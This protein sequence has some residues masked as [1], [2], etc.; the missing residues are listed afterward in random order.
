MESDPP[1][2]ERVELEPRY[3]GFQL[4]EPDL[5]PRDRPYYGVEQYLTLSSEWFE[6]RESLTALERAQQA[7]L[8]AYLDDRDDHGLARRL[9]DREVV[10]RW[11]DRFRI[12]GVLVVAI[13]CYLP[14]QTI[15]VRRSQKAVLLRDFAELTAVDH[16]PE[17]DARFRGYD[18][19]NPWGSCHSAIGNARPDSG[20]D[21]SGLRTD[22][23]L[24]ATYQDAERLMNQLPWDHGHQPFTIVA[25]WRF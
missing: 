12:A 20:Y 13:E 11:L 16:V 24:F 7:L 4:F 19:S 21:L 9:L 22:S 6:N 15:R 23:G 18:V 14:R 8:D 17:P 25:V 3:L 2:I 5:V 1:F 10:G